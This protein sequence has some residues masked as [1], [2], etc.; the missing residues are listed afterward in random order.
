ML[1]FQQKTFFPVATSGSFVVGIERIFWS[2]FSFSLHW[3]QREI[4]CHKTGS[5]WFH[6][7]VS[8]LVERDNI[9]FLPSITDIKAFRKKKNIKSKSAKKHK[10]VADP[11]I[12]NPKARFRLILLINPCRGVPLRNNPCAL[13]FHTAW[14]VQSPGMWW[15]LEYGWEG[16]DYL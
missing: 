8:F 6:D 15:E 12:S 14:V 10:A 9:I 11:E 5:I 13:G 3:I 16:W 1:A 4:I 2:T 7:S